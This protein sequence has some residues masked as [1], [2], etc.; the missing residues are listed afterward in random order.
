MAKELYQNVGS[1]NLIIH[2]GNGIYRGSAVKVKYG[3]YRMLMQSKDWVVRISED[4]YK[5]GAYMV[6]LFSTNTRRVK[7]LRKRLA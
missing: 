6:F 3:H 2:A 7:P 1:S 5:N 4:F